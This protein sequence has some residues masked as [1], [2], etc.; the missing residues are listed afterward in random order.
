MARVKIMLT[1]TKC[2][3]GFEH[4]HTCNNSAGAS[5]YTEWAKDNITICPDCYYAAKRAKEQATLENYMEGYHLPEITGVSDKQIA[6]ADKLRTSFMADLFRLKIDLSRFF[7]LADAIQLDKASEA[8]RAKM[9]ELAQQSGQTVEAWFSDYR[10]AKIAHDMGRIDKALIGK[11]E[12]VFAESNAS[13]I[14][15]ALK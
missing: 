11:I 6:F 5:S 15:D 12:T 9:A 4:I 8:G 13:K 14:I 3:K 1:C 7:R 10:T 2:G